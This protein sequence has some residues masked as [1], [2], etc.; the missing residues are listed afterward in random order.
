MTAP[1][2]VTRQQVLAHRVQAHGLDRATSKPA[3]L[4][5]LDLGVQ[6]TGS[7]GAP[8]ALAA[9][10]PDGK[11]AI[12]PT[13]VR[14]WSVRG[15]PHWYREG[16]VVAAAKALWPADDSDAGARLAGTG[17]IFRKAGIDPLD[18]LRT[19]AMALRKIV[20][21]PMAKGDVSAAVTEALPEEYSYFCRPCQATHIQDSLLRLAALPA[22]LRL[23]PDTSPPVLAPIPRWPG[24]PKEQ[25]GGGAVVDAY[26][27][28]HGPTTRAA[29]ATYLQTNQRAL[30][31]MWPDGLI[32]VR[33]D[34]GPA[35]LPE[36]LLD[37]LLAAPAPE[38]VRLVPACDPW[39][40]ARDRDLVVP[41]K[42]HHKALWPV[43]GW[44]GGV[45]VDGEI[46]GTWRTKATT[47]RLDVNVTAF[48]KL[49]KRVLADLE[50]EGSIV[51]RLRGLDDARVILA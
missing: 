25:S 8:A 3:D 17:T 50:D 9:R 27:R 32:E 46:V 41:K 15:A 49:P 39:L 43:I 45:L 2:K 38:L 5:I 11:G 30:K 20:K 18:G 22:G 51:A 33:V 26:L 29:T 47:K 13:W 21:K 4:A 35:W 40:L 31:P 14:T 10:L 42:A 37:D 24:V 12:P 34:G 48:A 36:E 16:D 1:P 7:G 6:D 19:A 23:E 44:P 28:I